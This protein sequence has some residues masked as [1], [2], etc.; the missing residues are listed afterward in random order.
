M[1]HRSRIL[2]RDDATSCRLFR[3][4]GSVWESGAIAARNDPMAASAFDRPLSRLSPRSAP[5]GSR[6][7]EGPSSATARHEYQWAGQQL[8]RKHR[9]QKCTRHSKR[10]NRLNCNG[11]HQNGPES[12]R[13]RDKES[14]Q[15]ARDGVG[16]EE[17]R[18]RG[19]RLRPA[20][21]GGPTLPSLP[22]PMRTG[23]ASTPPTHIHIPLQPPLMHRCK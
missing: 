20:S 10:H 21:D 1:F 2:A 4:Y 6:G 22:G 12:C 13:D 3:R 16:M 8:L 19:G 11:L 17:P 15:R 9:G 23:A 5:S 14:A 18:R 7:H